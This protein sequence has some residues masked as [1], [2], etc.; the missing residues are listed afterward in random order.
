MRALDCVHE[1]HDDVHFTGTTDDDLIKQVQQHRDEY[2][3]EMTDED[4]R[5]VV[6]E[7]AYDE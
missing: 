4:V 5:T 2:H 6:A 1:A 7:G 3:P